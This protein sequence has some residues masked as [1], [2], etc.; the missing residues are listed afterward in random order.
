MIFQ[1]S[2]KHLWGYRMDLNVDDFVSFDSL[3][4][5]FKNQLVLFCTTHNLMILKDS[6]QALQLHIHD[7]L[8][9]NDLKNHIDRLTNERIVYICDHQ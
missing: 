7:C 2:S 8:T 6:V 5:C 9:L 4:S 3:L 1:L